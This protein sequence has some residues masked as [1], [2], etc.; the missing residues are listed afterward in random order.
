MRRFEYKDKKSHKFWEIS[1]DA[2]SITVRWG[3]MGTKGQ[4]RTKAV[5]NPETEAE[6]KIKAKVKKGY[7][8]VKDEGVLEA[9]PPKVD[10]NEAPVK[11]VE[12]DEI[13]TDTN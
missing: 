13:E 11:S 10:T 1:F 2:T 5:A 3:R 8:A 6:K 9:E 4:S 7:V 12:E